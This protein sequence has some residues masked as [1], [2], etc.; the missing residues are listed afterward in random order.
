VRGNEKK[1]VIYLNDI[2]GFKPDEISVQ[3]TGTPPNDNPN[4]KNPND[5]S[6]LEIVNLK[7]ELNQVKNDLEKLKRFIIKTKGKNK[8]SLKNNPDLKKIIEESEEQLNKLE[9]KNNS[10]Q[11]SPNKGF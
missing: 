11:T 7:A 3:K 2:F 10:S 1:L 8:G 9:N 4:D 6:K 5:Q